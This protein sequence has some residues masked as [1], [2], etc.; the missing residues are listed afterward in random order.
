MATILGRERQA[1]MAI[2]GEILL[3]RAPTWTDIYVPKANLAAVREV[4]R[5]ERVA[6]DLTSDSAG[7][8]VEILPL[9]WLGRNYRRTGEQ[10]EISLPVGRGEK[11]IKVRAI[12]SYWLSKAE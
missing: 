1:G 3:H 9:G 4:L 6:Y 11:K 2:L 5:R 12:P 10:K 7:A 8:V